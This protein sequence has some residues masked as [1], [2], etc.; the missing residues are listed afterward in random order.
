MQMM[1]KVKTYILCTC[2][3]CVRVH[4]VYVYILCMCTYCVCVHHQRR[5]LVNAVVS[6]NILQK[7]KTLRQGV[8]GQI[9]NNQMG[10]ECCIYRGKEKCGQKFGG[11]N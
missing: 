5:A 2:T 7:N 11:K 1:L 8:G 9:K 4:T 6:K 3:Y 10:G